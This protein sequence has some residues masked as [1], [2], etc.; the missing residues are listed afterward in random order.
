MSTPV[1]APIQFFFE[2]AS[3]YSYLA[4]LEIET[5]ASSA[6]RV[7][8]WCP[9]EIT[10]VWAAHGVLEA[11]RTIRRL[12]SPYIR[13]DAMRCAKMKGVDMA[14][15]DSSSLDANT[16]KLVYWGLRKDDPILAKR[17]LQMV[18]HRYFGEGHSINQ[19]SD[20]TDSA[21]KIGLSTE[22]LHTAAQWLG[23]RQ[24]Q[25]QSNSQAIESGCFGVP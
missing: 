17:F 25:D 23:S 3:P 8:D 2:F 16:A 13:Q 7:V 22:S 6:E 15:P 10:S 18:W 9:I 12:K 11:Y 14:K 19:L 1:L 21:L 24:A 5:I 20:L 4:S